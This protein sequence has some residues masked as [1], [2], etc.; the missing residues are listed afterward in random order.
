MGKSCQLRPQ[1]GDLGTAI[2][3]CESR[4]ID[5]RLEIPETVAELIKESNNNRNPIY[6]HMHLDWQAELEE[7]GTHVY[8]D[9]L[10]YSGLP[11]LNV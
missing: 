11:N 8:R 9:Y 3:A 7:I 2:K 6:F 1:G 4:N 10:S 5:V